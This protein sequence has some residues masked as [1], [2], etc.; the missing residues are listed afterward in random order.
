MEDIAPV[1][2]IN[3]EHS[4]SSLVFCF[5]FFCLLGY[6]ERRFLFHLLLPSNH[7][8]RCGGA[9]HTRHT[10]YR[11]G[12]AFVFCFVFFVFFFL[13]GGA[14]DAV[15]TL[16]AS[17]S[18]SCWQRLSSSC[19]RRNSGRRH[20]A[21]AARWPSTKVD[22]AERTNSCD[23]TYASACTIDTSCSTKPMF[24]NVSAGSHHCRFVFFLTIS[25]QLELELE[26]DGESGFANDVRLDLGRWAPR[27][28][29][30]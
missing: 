15:R 2:V 8:L 29:G 27:R 17:S 22:S 5:V 11:S 10:L 7:T 24:T 12:S 13:G 16:Q 19:C 30:S 1:T 14:S 28:R 25:K 3:K 4:F 23:A 21:S 6:V 18:R 26:L 9:I 20:S